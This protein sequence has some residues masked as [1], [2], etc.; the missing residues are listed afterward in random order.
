M[1]L[2]RIY[3]GV[4]AGGVGIDSFPNGP[5]LSTSIASK[6]GGD[7]NIRIE[8]GKADFS[9]LLQSMIEVELGELKRRDRGFA[10][11]ARVM[12]KR[13]HLG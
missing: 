3:Y 8:I 12:A 10:R 9:L 11:A 6:G 1:T 4:P 13:D 7:T 5:S 2:P